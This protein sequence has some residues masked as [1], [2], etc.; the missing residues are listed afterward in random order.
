MGPGLLARPAGTRSSP[1]KRHRTTYPPLMGRVTP[2]RVLASLLL[3]GSALVA[4]TSLTVGAAVMLTDHGGSSD[5]DWLSW[6]PLAYI[7]SAPWLMIATALVGALVLGI[8][9]GL[10]RIALS[11]AHSLG[12][13][14]RPFEQH[15]N[16]DNHSP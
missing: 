13:N 16:T 7:L 10:A 14:E 1:A 9:Q 11:L 3:A 5:S 2:T 8:G 12:R 15:T 4:L 6:K